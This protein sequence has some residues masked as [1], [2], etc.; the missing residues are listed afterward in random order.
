MIDVVRIIFQYT[1]NF[2]MEKYR[3]SII[4]NVFVAGIFLLLAV[5]LIIE[6]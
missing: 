4:L 2:I 5:A 3:R 6:G 1:E